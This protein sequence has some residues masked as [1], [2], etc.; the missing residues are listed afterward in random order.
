MTERRGAF[1]VLVRSP[2]GK[3][4]LGSPRIR[5]EDNIKMHLQE[6]G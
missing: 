2:G 5:G 6:V 1:W 4:P 3:R